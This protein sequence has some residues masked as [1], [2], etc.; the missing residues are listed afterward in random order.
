[1][2][3]PT[4][5]E[6]PS[7]PSGR[8][9]WPWTEAG[10]H[11]DAAPA[12]GH[13]WPRISVVMPSYNQGAFLEAAIR[14]VLLQGYPD[15]ELVVVDGGSSDRSVDVI[16]RYEPWLASWCSEPDG[17]CA[18]ALN[19]GFART[20]GEILGYLNSD[21]WY[22]PGCFPGVARAM[23]AR[24]DA[25]VVYGN[26]CFAGPSERPGRPLFSD[27]WSLR[28]FAYRPSMLLQQATFFRRS[29]LEKVGGFNESNRSC[30]DAEL[31]ADMALAGA[32]FHRIEGFLGAFRVHGDS[33]TGS[34]RLRD[35]FRREI[36]RVREKI[37]GRPETAADRAY[38]LSLRLAR[39]GAHPVR[40]VGDKRFVRSVLGRWSL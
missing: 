30:W 38:A 19:K 3:C 36:R 8:R 15:V 39:F 17:G 26:G 7:P 24:P 21:D 37:L 27:A 18:H 13:A 25:G 20:T 29:A 12:N 4:L 31:V 33:I 22:L 40:I 34:A 6:L 5:T 35:D 9:G 10:S 28:R 16:A 32:R 14:S 23:E 2:R 1:M 11:P